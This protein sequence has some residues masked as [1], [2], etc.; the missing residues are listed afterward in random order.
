MYLQR[1]K[2]NICMYVFT[3]D[4]FEGDIAEQCNEGELQWIDKSE[5]TKLNIWEGDKI[6][7][8]KIKNDDNFFTVKFE[9]NGEKLIRYDLKEY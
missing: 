4:D 3:S 6:F 2:Q 8:D 7:I 9:Y 5:I 1:G